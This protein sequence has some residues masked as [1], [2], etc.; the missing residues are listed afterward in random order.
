[1]SPA[2][3]DVYTWLA[4]FDM[5]KETPAIFKK[6]IISLGLSF[7]VISMLIGFV[8][9]LFLK[10]RKSLH[11]DAR[12][13]NANE[14]DKSG[15]TGKD[16]IIVGKW[17]NK[18]LSF[19]GMQFVLLAAPTRSGKG[20]GIVIPNLLSFIE[21]I[22]VLDVKLENFKITSKFRQKNG[23]KVF[24][25]NPFDKDGVSH[26]YNPLGYISKDSRHRIAD[27]IAIGKA[28]YPGGGKDSF[29]DDAAGDI[30]LGL[31]LFLTETPALPTTIGELLRQ[32]S[33][34]G[35]PIKKHLEEIILE[36]NFKKIVTGSGDD[37]EV[38]YEEI[39]N[40]D[41]EG[42]KPLSM[43]CVDSFN[44][45]TST[46]DNTRSS[47]LATLTTPL[48][49]WVSPIV[50]AA[51]S[52]NDFDL[53]KVRREK[54]TI[55]VGIPANKLAE[56]KLLLN[57]FFSQLINL[58]TDDLIYSKPDIKHQCLILMDEFTASG[59]IG[60]IDSANSFM[61]G[62]GLRLLTIIQSPSQLEAEPNK[63]YGKD[64]ARTLITNHALQ[65][66]YTPR[67]Q[68]DAQE[69]S[70]M[71]GQH[72]QKA[73]SIQVGDRS[74]GSESEQ[75][76]ALMLPQELK[77]MSQEEQVII[78]ENTKAIQCE[79]IFYYKEPIFMN[80]LK[81]VS[82]T[83]KAI[84]ERLPTQDEFEGV[85]GGGELSAF[86]PTL[87]LDLHEALVQG[88]MRPVNEDDIKEG[89]QLE[90][91]SVNHD[92]INIIGAKATSASDLA[93]LKNDFDSMLGMSDDEEDKTIDLSSIELEDPDYFIDSDGSGISL[94]DDEMAALDAELEEEATLNNN[95]DDVAFIEEYKAEEIIDLDDN[96]FEDEDEQPEYY[97]DEEQDN[98][99]DLSKLN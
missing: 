45:F 64:G 30:F 52:D 99:I 88:R 94:S 15:L 86:V 40:W 85:W 55:Y 51:T 75:R 46:S 62:Y 58:N 63:G 76:R 98:T 97:D 79:K 90:K 11:G 3:N 80:R 20:V 74:K 67:L 12:F 41:G 6:V 60:I 91:L 47:I 49:L 37:E 71:L 72:G 42:L 77:E 93:K 32:S 57:M 27:I 9:F 82:P 26:R 21:S 16:G 28:L 43:E 5:Y 25:F 8:A 56:A 7:F 18:F 95:K 1:M 33:G 34:K 39:T 4:Y 31:V 54:T 92:G 10:D 81:T 2:A 84:G 87:D 96:P 19:P 13:A 38:E 66:L 24:L 29:F 70:D 89:I 14:I 59:R 78:M 68:K 73:R 48:T 17:R 50:D 36:R 61:A 83:L 53:S 35:K 69:Y 65:I 44:R 22:V 23:Q